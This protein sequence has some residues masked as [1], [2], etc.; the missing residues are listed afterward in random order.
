[1]AYQNAVNSGDHEAVCPTRAQFA[2]KK[3]CTIT[4]KPYTLT[5]LYQ[6]IGVDPTAEFENNLTY[7]EWRQEQMTTLKEVTANISTEMGYR[8]T[9][10]YT[11]DNGGGTVSSVISQFTV[12]DGDVAMTV[13]NA[14]RAQGYNRA[15][16]SGIMGNICQESHFNIGAVSSDGN[17]SYGICQWT[18]DRKSRLLACN[19]GTTAEGQ[20]TFL[21]LEIEGRMGSHYS[22]LINV[23][24]DEAGTL[25]ACDWFAYIFESPANVASEEEWRSNPKY[26][27]YTWSR[28]LPCSEY[29]GRYLLDAGNRRG[30]ALGYFND[31]ITYP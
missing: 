15:T 6:M 22:N 23:N 7:E 31:P 8:F 20:A 26:S 12:V 19:D 18:F 28:F 13:W 17:D 14:L 4:I 29:T 25:E 10:P 21:L 5:T 2:S 27:K 1:M 30:Y 16:A 24:E 11:Y 9:T 3:K